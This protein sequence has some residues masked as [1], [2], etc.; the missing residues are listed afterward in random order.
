[1]VGPRDSVKNGKIPSNLIRF[2]D[3]PDPCLKTP[4]R[5]QKPHAPNDQLN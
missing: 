2:D 3:F 1:L 4:S 5:T